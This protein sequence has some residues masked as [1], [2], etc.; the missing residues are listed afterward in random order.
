[1]Q[2]FSENQALGD[3]VRRCFEMLHEIEYRKVRCAEDLEPIAK[4]RQKAYDQHE[5]LAKPVDIG[6][7]RGDLDP[8]VHVFG[9]FHR[10]RLV[11]S[12][13]FDV[14]SPERRDSTCMHYF[15]DVLTPLLDQGFRFL[16]PTRFSVD[17]E[18]DRS[19]A[20]LPFITLRLSVL[21]MIHFNCDFGLCM[22]RR[23]HVGFYRKYFRATQICPFRTFE[24]ARE[25]Y[26][27]FSIPRRA[28][29]Q[30]I[31]R[32]PPFGSIAAERR[33]LFDPVPLGRPGADCVR[34]T[35]SLA[36]RLNGSNG[37]QLQAAG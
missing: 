18:V 24:I 30:I 21:A 8:D 26:G 19:M 32:Y 10:E 29:D 3:H 25:P 34:P 28:E 35:A 7:L 27:L 6:N 13:R 37:S 4:L 12:I 16:D 15:G 14:L 23:S 33:L 2:F 31:A 20:A 5:I 9:V 11:A 36:F 1:M 17:P 22:L